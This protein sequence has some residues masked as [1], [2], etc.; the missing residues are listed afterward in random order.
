MNSAQISQPTVIRSRWGLE[1]YLPLVLFLGFFFPNT[2][3]V[4]LNSLMLSLR[5]PVLLLVCGASVLLLSRK[6]WGIPRP[7]GA[8]L[9]FL[10][11][12]SIFAV[13]T[14]F[15]ANVVLAMAKLAVI[16]AFVVF[17]LL[18]FGNVRSREEALA[19]VWPLIVAI[20]VH[21]WASLTLGRFYPQ[22]GFGFRGYM[23]NPNGLGLFLAV[24][25]LPA[26]VFAV[27]SV[28]RQQEQ[29]F[30]G[31]TLL[32][33]VYLVVASGS[34]TASAIMVLVL[35]LS[36]WR[37]RRFQG[38]HVIALKLLV[39]FLGLLLLPLQT[40][41]I[42]AFAYK[43]PTASN[44][45][46]SRTEF[47]E[48]TREAIRENPWMGAGFGIQEKE[49]GAELGITTN[50]RLRRGEQ[51]ST[52]LG[53]VEEVGILGATPFFF[54][55]FVLGTRAGF[56]LMLSRDP[57]RLFLARVVVAGMIWGASE[58]YL[59]FLGNGASILVLYGIFLGERLEQL[60]R[61]YR[62]NLR[63]AR[64]RQRVWHQTQVESLP[65]TPGT[66]VLGT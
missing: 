36:F 40:Q 27:Q 29:I 56:V 37:W 58:N 45:L 20:A 65:S 48:D 11:C 38:K 39:I 19:I 16:V 54:M 22:F 51:G 15:S 42:R 61:A 32:V 8:G 30:Y 3:I 43:Y 64:E 7:H 2:R 10:F 6:G 21:S 35:G 33:Q 50:Y 18:F 5:W 34:R 49:A 1:R 23:T 63:K 47:W 41:R 60:H 66:P 46:A 12:F 44:I 53:M 52:Y 9:A 24:F 57:L 59:L 25:G 62:K 31:L 17:C 28:R 55:L 26:T 4:P 13:L 14:L